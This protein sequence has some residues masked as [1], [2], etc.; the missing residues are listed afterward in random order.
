LLSAGG[1]AVAAG[2]TAVY[3]GTNQPA[4]GASPVVPGTDASSRAPSARPDAS[5]APS[6]VS[7]PSPLAP[8]AGRWQSASGRDFSAVVAGEAGL[9]FRVLHASQHPRQGYEDGEV[10]FKLMPISGSTNEFAVEDHLRPTPLPGVEYDPKT[11]RESC[12]SIWTAVKGRKL[13]AQL[14]G[15]SSLNVDFVQIRTGPEKF[16]TQGKRVVGCVDLA[17]SPAEP[18]ESK[19][20]RAP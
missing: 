5:S 15:A 14:D 2:S 11:S 9:E 13:L 4:P 12:L 17:S 19:L 20:T 6:P 7:P 16:K 3:L 8:L 10:R 18:I 1:L